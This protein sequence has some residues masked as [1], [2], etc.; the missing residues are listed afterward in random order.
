MNGFL[1]DDLDR[2]L[3]AIEFG[4][5]Q[6]Q[7]AAFDGAESLEPPVVGDLREIRVEGLPLVG[8]RGDEA[9]G[10]LTLLGVDGEI[11]EH[12]GGNFP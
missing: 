6:A 9:R 10:K 11:V 1:Q 2:C 8:H 7:H 12:V 5:R 3:V 4:G